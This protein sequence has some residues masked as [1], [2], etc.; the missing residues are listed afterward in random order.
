MQVKY[1]SLIS[2]KQNTEQKADSKKPI[3]SMQSNP[4]L[5]F[6]AKTIPTSEN[7][8]AYFATTLPLE[9]TKKIGFGKSLKTH[10]EGL[11]PKYDSNNQTASV[12]VWAPN[13]NKMELQI[14]KIPKHSSLHLKYYD[15][16]IPASCEIIPMQKQGDV[17]AIENIDLS[18]ISVTNVDGRKT[19]ANNSAYKVLYRLNIAERPKN[20]S[21]H[22]LGPIKDPRGEYLP[23]GALN[24][25][26]FVDHN[27]FKW[28]ESEKEW[29]KPA[30]K[31]AVFNEAGRI[32]LEGKSIEERNKALASLRIYECNVGLMTKNGNFYELIKPVSYKKFMDK[33]NDKGENLDPKIKEELQNLSK[34]NKLN[35][36]S[37]IK[38]LGY[39]AIEF[40][41][42]NQFS[43]NF[44]WGYDNS[45]VHAI[46]HSYG[47]PEG[48]KKA[49]K[50]AHKAGLNV[51]QDVQHNH[52]A[53]EGFVL[54]SFGPYI[55]ASGEFG[56]LFNLDNPDP[57]NK[58][59]ENVRDHFVDSTI[60]LLENYHLD[61][62]RFDYTKD[63][64]LNMPRQYGEEITAH[65]PNAIITAED[66]RKRFDVSNPIE[67]GD[68]YVE[69]AKTDEYIPPRG[70]SDDSRLK[71]MGLVQWNTDSSHTAEALAVGE[72]T[73]GAPPS[74]GRL[75]EHYRNGFSD[76]KMPI[77]DANTVESVLSHDESGN[78]NK[79]LIAKI[80]A[81]SLGIFNRINGGGSQG[82]IVINALVD[83]YLKNDRKS[84]MSETDQNNLGVTN[85]VNYK[86]FDSAY[87]RAEA[88]NRLALTELH[89]RSGGP[90]MLYQGEENEHNRFTF[91]MDLSP[92]RVN[93][94]SAKKG[95]DAG[96]TTYEACK[97]DNYEVDTKKV[98]LLTR[99]A[100]LVKENEAL[101]SGK[102]EYGNLIKDYVLEGGQDKVYEVLR[103][104]SSK[105]NQIMT[106]M[107]Y[108][109]KDYNKYGLKMTN[110]DGQPNPDW[111]LS[112][113]TWQVVL[114][115]EDKK[116]SNNSTAEE[117]LAKEGTTFTTDGNSEIVMPLPRNSA[118]ML[119]KISDNIEDK[120][121]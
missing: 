80:A 94:E 26:E 89:I 6:A 63:Q 118:I 83:S 111:R 109:D 79:N 119:K 116:Y 28:G 15:P 5:N 64:G 58:A 73:M 117:L 75:S 20:F 62:I 84:I 115:T 17:F 1:S 101:S 29:N 57:N 41:P 10:L 112:K 96:Y 86:E 24:W 67:P 103:S 60:K 48:F 97:L 14:I 50:E 47:G 72:E 34:Q 31:G 95:Y 54:S 110:K 30:S 87:K 39:N 16:K 76:Y 81:K 56:G 19:D 104:N 61:G 77:G 99:L 100:D 12:K 85:T 46:Q 45:D 37:Y 13:V 121:N 11:G 71:N 27:N 33:F 25:N 21:H 93:Q 38:A 4:Y 105:D 120:V 42:V 51:I 32:Q 35:Q 18:K 114:N 3:N 113:G 40:M 53:P 44:G 55:G 23:E 9:K 68:P 82:N 69:S 90:K 91:F 106:I 59:C 7:Y 8:K 49:V 66:N 22:S 88:R 108:G 2:F 43:G 70:N 102:R 107:N 98:N 65:Y 92:E 52:E 78:H 74:L 36:L